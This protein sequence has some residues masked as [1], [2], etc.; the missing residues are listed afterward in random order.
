[1]GETNIKAILLL[2]NLAVGIILFGACAAPITP[3]AEEI[4]ML[5]P[6]PTSGTA[7]AFVNADAKELAPRLKELCTTTTKST[8]IIPITGTV[9]IVNA[10]TGEVVMDIQELLVDAAQPPFFANILLTDC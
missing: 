6:A 2:L 3:Q 9:L 10:D 7:L 1:M 4:P 8:G 5:T